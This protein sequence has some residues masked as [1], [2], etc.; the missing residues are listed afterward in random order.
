MLQARES[1]HRTK[2]QRDSLYFLAFCAFLFLHTPRSTSN[3][4]TLIISYISG[5][6]RI[7]LICCLL[8]SV[9]L[10]QAQVKL[11]E[12]LA[13]EYIEELVLNLED[14][15]IE[16]IDYVVQLLEEI[17]RKPL[18]LNRDDLAPLTNIGLLTNDQVVTLNAHKQE[19]GALLAVYE[20]QSIPGWDLNTIRRIQPLIR[21]NRNLDDLNLSFRDLVASS[22]LTIRSFLSRRFPDARGSIAPND[23]TPPAY[24]GDS[25][26]Q[27]VRIRAQY[28]YRLSAGLTLEKDAGEALFSKSNKNG[29]DYTSFH[30]YG[31]KVNRFIDLIALGDY[32]VN[33]GQGLILHNGFG[34]NKSAYVTNVK[35]GGKFFRPHS[36]TSEINF[37]RGGGLSINVAPNIQVAAF[38]SDVRRDANIVTDTIN[39]EVEIIQFT[40]LQT[41]G[42]HRTANEIE[43]E[44][45]IHYRAMGGRL[46]YEKKK[47]S[48]HLN[49]LHNKFDSPFSR[50]IQPYNQYRFTGDKLTNAS[51]DYSY[52]LGRLHL[53]G[54]SAMSDN[55]V[56]AHLI[57][58]KAGLSKR[59]KWIGLYRH[60][61]RDYQT[62]RAN[63]F[64]ESRDGNNEIGF[65]NGLEYT[66]NPKFQINAYV[67]LWSN[68]WLQ[69][70][71]DAITKGR[72]YLV[73][74][75]YYKKRKI[76]AYAQYKFEEKAVAGSRESGFTGIQLRVRNQLRC[77][78][79]YKVNKS[80]EWRS[81]VEFNQVKFND[82]SSAGY[83]VYQ[84]FIYKPI[85][86]DFSFSARYAF[87]D[88]DDSASRIYMYENNLLY[89]YS[90]PSFANTGHRFY[91]NLR[92]RP[93]SPLTLELRYDQT[94]F[95]GSDVKGISSGTE[96]REGNRAHQIAMQISWVFN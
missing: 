52:S 3:P 84:D 42:L 10:V 1:W 8:L 94:V 27:F 63:A 6:K 35:K 87:F 55:G 49:V 40:S 29:Y 25:Y 66:I 51:V 78:L 9:V 81:R 92:Y 72:E 12:E 5:V 88:T 26:R 46:G 76:E 14:D 69:F 77:H 67:D 11:S 16:N 54:E 30:L 37:F 22:T 71:V 47:I 73:K 82:R 18:D 36:S 41:S 68:P 74:F 86:S 65:Y 44:K 23:T 96:L 62:I 31:Q 4:S 91:I 7:W 57:G 48:I 19:H 83:L 24:E 2:N 56:M 64:G 45:Q 20:L 58:V 93:I 28:Q 89:N 70:N 53:F 34:G 60:Y 33:M 32:K 59:M 79:N 39:E 21:V 38:Y 90:L 61:P 75:R 95:S 50:S 13:R 80:L 85:Q 43:D 15:D 17:A